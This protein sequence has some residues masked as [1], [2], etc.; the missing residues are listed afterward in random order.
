[1]VRITVFCDSVVIWPDNI[2]KKIRNFHLIYSLSAY[3]KASVIIESSYAQSIFF[4][5]KGYFP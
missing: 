1:M 4:E 5:A 3:S 2:A